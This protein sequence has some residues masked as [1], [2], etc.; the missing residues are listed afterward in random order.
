MSCVRRALV[1]AVFFIGAAVGAAGGGAGTARAQEVPRGEAHMPEIN[2]ERLGR[3]ILALDP[4]A[5]AQG[6]G[7]RLS[8][9]GQLV[10]L[11]TDPAAGRLRAMVPVRA[12]SGLTAPQLVRLLGANFNTALDARYAIAEGLVWSIFVRPLAGL[13]KVQLISGLAQV[14]TLARSYGTSYSSGAMRFGPRG[15][16]GDPP[17]AAL[18]ERLL[19]RGQDI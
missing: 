8:I 16:E 11:I 3:L 12:A 9:E 15:A 5:V 2:A 1:C 19:R 18:I 10:L 4:D 14:V 17:D 13:G 7:W 6:N